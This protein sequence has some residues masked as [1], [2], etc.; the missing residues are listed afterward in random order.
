MEAI[1]PY[2]NVQTLDGLPLSVRLAVVPGNSAI[3]VTIELLGDADPKH[4]NHIHTSAAHIALPAPFEAVPQ[5][6]RIRSV[7]TTLLKADG[8]ASR[9]LANGSVVTT[10]VSA[11]PPTSTATLNESSNLEA[12]RSSRLG[13]ADL[14]RP[15]LL[16]EP[17]LD[18]LRTFQ[19]E[20][21]HW[22]TKRPKAILADDMGLG[23][24]IQAISALR[25]LFNA[26]TVR[27][28]LI[29]C[30][31]SL[32]AHWDE[33]LSRWAPELGRVRLVPT[34]SIREQAWRVLGTACHVILTNYEQMRNPPVE[35]T[36]RGIDITIADEAHRMRNIGSQVARG[37][38]N[39][40]STSFWALTGTPVERDAED[41]ATILSL[42]EP[43]HFSISDKNLH[44][45][46]LRAQARPYVLRRLKSQVLNELPSVWET[47]QSLE[48]LPGQRASYENTLQ[49]LAQSDGSR[50]LAGINDLRSI[51]D[52][53]DRT[54][55]S[56]QAG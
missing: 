27:T 29:I 51:C 28:A 12:Y 13:A 19:L 4:P 30:P 2:H 31:K 1:M 23:K 38:R 5:E 32:L 50:V 39:I 15:M 11:T 55:E 43:N 41:L 18:R 49:R 34:A 26:G 37:I 8:Q 47:Q 36:D 20:G 7:V 6:D 46:S 42:L 9:N 17:T 54:G 10:R 21:V 24:T 16:A 22:L 52:F 14:I 48:L 53:D 44:P 3:D 45:T 25:L 35:L 40:K 56:V 33:E